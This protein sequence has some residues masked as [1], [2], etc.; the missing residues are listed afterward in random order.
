[1]KLGPWNVIQ[2]LKWWRKRQEEKPMCYLAEA[3]TSGPVRPEYADLFGSN[4]SAVLKPGVRTF[5]FS[6][7]R[8][9]DKFCEKT[10]AMKK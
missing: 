10:G 6:D 2:S 9:R 5:A 4:R 7:E 8:A 1:M 3:R